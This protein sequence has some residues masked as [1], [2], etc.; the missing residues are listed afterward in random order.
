V[1]AIAALCDILLDGRGQEKRDAVTA[2]SEVLEKSA[3]GRQV[4]MELLR[5]RGICAQVTY[6]YDLRS[7]E[8]RATATFTLDNLVLSSPL[9]QAPAGPQTPVGKVPRPVDYFTEE[10]GDVGAGGGDC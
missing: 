4:A 5:E 1:P 8:T 10:P 6:A 7:C 9:A 3:G 2:L